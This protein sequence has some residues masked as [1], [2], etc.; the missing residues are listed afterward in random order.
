MIRK[1]LESNL[2]AG[3][4]FTV[5]DGEDLL[6]YLHHRGRHTPASASPTPGI[7]LLDL[8]MPKKSGLE[9][10]AGIR[11]DSAFTANTHRH[12]DHVNQPR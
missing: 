7:I 8:N 1:A 6:D 3:N 10:L 4:F 5:Q 12:P 11:A 9:A 2:H